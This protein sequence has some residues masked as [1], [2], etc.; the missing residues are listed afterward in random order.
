MLRGPPNHPTPEQGGLLRTAIDFLTE[1]GD[2]EVD[3]RQLGEGAS[4]TE[5][6]EDTDMGSVSGVLGSSVAGFDDEN[7][8]GGSETD[9]L[10]DDI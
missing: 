4:E 3:E 9:S 10:H 6:E 8:S 1:Q 7:A 5:E 2:G